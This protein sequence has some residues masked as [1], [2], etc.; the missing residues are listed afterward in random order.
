VSGKALRSRRRRRWLFWSRSP[1]LP[2]AASAEVDVD[3]DAALATLSEQ[4]RSA[5]ILCHLEG[6]SRTEA[7]KAL[8]CPEGTLSARLSRGLE[9]LRQKLGKPPLAIL[10]AATVVM[11]PEAL[12]AMTVASVRHL[13]EG[14]LDEWASPQTVDLFRKAQP[15][16][17]LHRA[18][19]AVGAVVAVALVM[20]GVAFGWNLIEAQ[21]SG[22]EPQSEA[23]TKVDPSQISEQ[24][25]KKVSSPHSSTGLKL[26][27]EVKKFNDRARFDPI[28][29][30]QS[31]LTVDEVVAAI[32]G[33]IR[34]TVPVDD[35]VY[36]EYLRIAETKMLPEGATLTQ[37]TSWAGYN[38]HVFDVWWIDLNIKLGEHSGYTF[39]IRDQKIRC[40]PMTEAERAEI[41]SES[42]RMAE[43]MVIPLKF[44]KA[45]SVA[46]TLSRTIR[47]KYPDASVVPRVESNTIIIRAPRR[48]HEAI[49]K[50]V[51]AIDEINK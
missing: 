40:R 24:G 28:G 18:G 31:P 39:R 42:D 46:D 47:E 7:A 15:M 34:K 4:E 8:G 45:A 14:T 2:A 29:E 5:I 26:A 12:P 38:N 20:V 22:K 32:R 13:R 1:D 17:V 44:S 30:K 35:N 36:E 49:S 27:D 33:W 19:P 3:L 48:K 6:L 43:I 10:A 50:A 51:Q 25:S 23:R 41:K 11:L 16:N 21:E 9:K 37:C